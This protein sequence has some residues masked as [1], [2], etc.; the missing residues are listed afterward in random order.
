MIK[1][2]FVGVLLTVVGLIFWIMGATDPDFSTGARIAAFIF[3]LI[4]LAVPFV[5]LKI[6]LADM[7]GNPLQ[8][9]KGLFHMAKEETVSQVKEAVLLNQEGIEGGN[10]TESLLSNFRRDYESFFLPDSPW[11]NAPVQNEAAQVLWNMLMLRKNRLKKLGITMRFHAKRMRYGDASVSC[12]KYSDGKYEIMDVSEDISAEAEYSRQ[13]RR[14]FKRTEKEIAHYTLLQSIEKRAGKGEI[15]PDCGA[16]S[17]R[18]NLLDG[19]DYCGTVF[20]VEDLGTK[21]SDFAMRKDPDIEYAKYK[22]IRSKMTVWVSLIIGIVVFLWSL[23]GTIK[24]APGVAAENGN[25]MAL[26]AAVSVLVVIFVTASFDFLLTLLFWTF[27]FPFVQLIASVGY[28]SRK[29][30]KRMKDAEIMDRAVEKKVRSKDPLF[31]KAA[32]YAGLQNK[33]AAVHFA[34]TQQQAEAF[35]DC[36]MKSAVAR[37]QKVVDFDTESLSMK[38]FRTEKGMN[39]I[40][41]EARLKL[42][43]LDGKKCRTKDEKIMVTMHKSADCKTQAV[44]GPSVMKCKGCGSSLSLLNGKACSFCGAEL[45]LSDYDWTIRSYQ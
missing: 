41:V 4:F 8:R 33:L 43:L 22:N 36:S 18:E 24:V 6:I 10:K 28:I 25:N 39:I 38:K 27:V 17:T 29:A 20:T 7:K 21:V 45:K 35:A 3:G 2:I 13:G 19:C 15:C 23:Y 5:I 16:A 1:E 31:S 34:G 14:I 42:I 9:L 40:D 44:C 11:E 12:R 30:Y 26:I 32:F 37:Y